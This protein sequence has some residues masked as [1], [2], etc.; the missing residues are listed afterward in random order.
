MLKTL[1]KYRKHVVVRTRDPAILETC[2]VVLD[3]GGV[4]DHEK[5]RYDHHQRGFTE[6]MNSVLGIDFHTK[7]SSAGLVYAHY[8]KEVIANLLKLYKNFVESV[9]AIDNGIQQFDGEPRYML[10]STLNSRISDLNPAWNDNTALPDNQFSKAMDVVKEEFEAKVNYLFNSWIPAR[11]LVVQA[12]G[13][14]SRCIL[15]GKF[16]PLNRLGF[17]TKITSSN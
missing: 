9:D 16:W 1:P 10:S 2:D 13:N 11:E 15:V 4:Y 3:V 14:E 12:I 7:L 5:K 17:P 6:T 8:G